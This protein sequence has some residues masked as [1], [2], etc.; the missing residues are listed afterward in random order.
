[1]DKKK[2]EYQKKS[3]VEIS[4]LIDS[5]TSLFATNELV[6][7]DLAIHEEHFKSEKFYKQTCC[8]AN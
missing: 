5:L 3:G 7:N 1:M 2:N 8:K 4:I 6:I